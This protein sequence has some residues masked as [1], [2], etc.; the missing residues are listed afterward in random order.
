VLLIAVCMVQ[1]CLVVMHGRP[2]SYIEYFVVLLLYSLHF[3]DSCLQMSAG[4]KGK[5]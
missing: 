4:K 1:P 3:G 2:M 5:L